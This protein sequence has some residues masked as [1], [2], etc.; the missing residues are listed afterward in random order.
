MH[1]FGRSGFAGRSS[2]RHPQGADH[3]GA[4]VQR[5]SAVEQVGQF[6]ALPAPE[7]GDG[8]RFGDAAVGEGA[9]G[10]GGT[11]TGT[12][13]SSSRTRAVWAC[14]GGSARMRASSTVP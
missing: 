8:F 11:D 6:G 13:I 9:A 2:I 5:R 10:A 14:V 7:A 12:A 4:S 3:A 1:L